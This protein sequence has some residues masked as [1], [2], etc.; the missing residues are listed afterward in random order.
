MKRIIKIILAALLIAAIG[1]GGYFYFQSRAATGTDTASTGTYTQVVQVKQGDLSS[2]LS[3][4]GQLE[5]EQSSSLA[6]EQMS[7]TANLLTLAVQAGN[8]VTKGQVLATIDSAPYQQA[9]DQAKSDLLAAEETL[10]DLNEP[11]TA[12]DIA[13]ADVAVATAEQTLEQAKS[14][15]AD[16]GAPDLT[17]LENAVKDAEDNLALCRSRA[18][19]PN[20]IPWRRA[21]VISATP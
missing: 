13:Q 14:D 4:V 9:L 17:S 21:S 11:A 20:A 2:S 8:I 7:G 16:L 19:W 3:V 15:L 12:L 1:G 10:A 5:A 6:F 18:T